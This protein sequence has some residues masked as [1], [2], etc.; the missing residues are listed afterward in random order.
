M[1]G[2]QRPARDVTPHHRRC[3]P[4]TGSVRHPPD[5]PAGHLAVQLR[6][7]SSDRRRRRLVHRPVRAAGRRRVVR[8]P[9][10]H[11][12][13]RHPSRRLARDAGQCD[14]RGDRRG[15]RRR[16]Q[17]DADRDLGAGLP[18]GVAGRVAP[19][20]HVQR[21]RWRQRRDG[22]Q[23]DD[24][25]AHHER[26]GAVRISGHGCARRRRR[27][28]HRNSAA[29]DPSP[30]AVSTTYALAAGCGRAGQC[31]RR[32][33][34]AEPRVRLR[35]RSRRLRPHGLLRQRAHGPVRRRLPTGDE[36]A[37]R[38]DPLVVP[39][40]DGAHRQRQRPDDA[41]RGDGAV[42][43]VLHT[44]DRSSAA[45][46]SPW[47]A[48]SSTAYEHHWWWPMGATMGNDGQLYVFSMEVVERGRLTSPTPSQLRRGCR[49]CA[50][51]T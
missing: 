28:V 20:G 4:G 26:C 47:I 42:R 13:G 8:A 51:R 48:G 29:D 39:G 32:R 35:G 5:R 23:R 31:L 21:Q 1:A 6:R 16:R 9:R 38:P 3:G 24:R 11:P 2:G 44:R 17:R 45:S 10:T 14:L 37:R 27:L 40:R 19:A 22:R 43:A 30:A 46:P 49:P 50:C 41:Q 25:A 34:R 36:A 33:Q 12:R 7:R 15:C 18:H